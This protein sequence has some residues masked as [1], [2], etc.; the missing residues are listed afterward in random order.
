MASP[1]SDSIKSLYG[2]G[3]SEMGANP[4]MGLDEMRDLFEHWGD[5][6][7]EPGEVDYIEVDAGG[8]RAMWAIP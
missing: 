2:H 4:D 6:T 7:G 8:V 5:I 3:L 1:Q